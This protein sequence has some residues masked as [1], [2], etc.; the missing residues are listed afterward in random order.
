LTPIPEVSPNLV[1]HNAI[2]RR[3][4]D[5]HLD[6][7]VG[8]TAIHSDQMGRFKEE[9]LYLQTNW[10]HLYKCIDE[11]RISKFSC[12]LTADLASR[13]VDFDSIA[14][15]GR[16]E[17][18][19]KAQQNPMV[20]NVGIQRLFELVSPGHDIGNLS[21]SY[22]ILDALGGDGVLAR[23]MQE[24]TTEA[25][26][27]S[28]LTSDLSEEMVAA[29]RS[30]GLF[31]LRQPAQALLLKTDSLDGVIIAYGTH[32]IP[33]DHRL[34][35]CCEAFRVLK[36]GSRVVL[37]DFEMDSPM[38]LWFSDVVDK[39]SLTGHCFPHFTREEMRGYLTDAG[40]LDVQVH[41]SYDPFILSGDSI[42]EVKRMLAEYI[43][44]MYGLAKL[45]DLCGYEEA[46]NRVY[47]LLLKYFKYDY[48]KMG[49]DE[50]FGAPEVTITKKDDGYTIEA[51]RIALVGTATK[52]LS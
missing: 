38:S 40:F 24:M 50:R 7:L 12:L 51:P 13:M 36:G 32:H 22:R 6:S 48:E 1:N 43:L 42:E 33:K 15:G 41:Y 30:Y 45:V 18:Y 8:N 11:E 9:L 47:E 52:P 28:I 4:M 27:P 20:R 21:A 34:Q 17:M 29:A 37:H 5:N 39:Y 23:A 14:Q 10:P 49:L 26:M 16:G 3:K 25:T 2:R 35:A 31:A 44:D 46:I 19:R